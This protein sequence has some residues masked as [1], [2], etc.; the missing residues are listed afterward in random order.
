M[1]EAVPATTL[2]SMWTPASKFPWNKFPSCYAEW[3]QHPGSLTQR[4]RELSQGDLS[5]VLLTEGWQ[6]VPDSELVPLNKQEGSK[7]WVREIVFYGN[8]QPW[9]WAKTIIPPQSLVEE[10]SA[11]LHLGNQSIGDVLFTDPHLTRSEFEIAQLTIQHPYYQ[12]ISAYL[13][14]DIKFVWARRSIIYFHRKPL[15][16][17]E[18]FLPDVFNKIV[19]PAKDDGNY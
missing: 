19:V 2:S 11:F 18:L 17:Y 10:G 9:E 4:F 8:Q 3:L 7:V 14:K 5:H 13:N 12:S 15:L 1:L 16:I 6:T